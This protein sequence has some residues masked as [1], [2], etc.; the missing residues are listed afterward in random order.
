M[1]SYQ[2]IQWAYGCSLFLEFSANNTILYCGFAV[3]VKYVEGSE[4]FNQGLLVP[5]SL[6]TFS[7]AIF[8]FGHGDAGNG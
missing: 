2:G 4:K 5:G 3:K 6:G 7:Y 1:R 8:Q